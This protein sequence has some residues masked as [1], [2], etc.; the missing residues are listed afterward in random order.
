MDMAGGG[1]AEGG[2]DAQEV[3]VSNPANPTNARMRKPEFM[4]NILPLFIS[5][6]CIF[7]SIQGVLK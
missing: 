1:G 5:M 6:P 7:G 2:L 3:R 4:K